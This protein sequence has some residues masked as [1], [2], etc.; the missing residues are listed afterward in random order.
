MVSP[1]SI[2]LFNQVFLVFFWEAGS[3]HMEEDVII[4]GEK[5]IWCSRK[6][7]QLSSC[8]RKKNVGKLYRRKLGVSKY[9]ES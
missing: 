8:E 6:K 7:R 1:C 9:T 4:V 2:S 3:E 5:K